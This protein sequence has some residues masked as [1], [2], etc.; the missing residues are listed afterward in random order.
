MDKPMHH[1]EIK[2]FTQSNQTDKIFESE[3]AKEEVENKFNYAENDLE[4]YSAKL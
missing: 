2:S 1:E 3:K 4:Q